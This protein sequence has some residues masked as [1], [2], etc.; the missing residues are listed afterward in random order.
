[1]G[2]RWYGWEI[3]PEEARQAALDPWP[4]IRIADRRYGDPR[5]GVID[6]DKAWVGMQRLFS[7]PRHT[8]NPV[9]RAAFGLVAGDVTYPLG[10]SDGYEPYVAVIDVAT[11]RAIARDLAKVDDGDVRAYAEAWAPLGYPEEIQHFIP[12]ARS[13]AED[14]AARG[15]CIIYVI[16]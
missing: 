16:Q 10:Y 6:L 12:V 7:D 14:A 1:M 9:P 8:G 3:S 13:F 11:V 15:N 2:I 4:I 5:W